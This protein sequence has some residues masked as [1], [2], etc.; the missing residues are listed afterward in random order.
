MSRLLFAALIVLVLG[1]PAIAQ[2]VPTTEIFGGYSWSH[3]KSIDKNSTG[4]SA[5][6]T[7]NFNNW[8]GLSVGGGASYA[9]VQ[10]SGIDIDL[11]S[12]SVAAGPRFSF[13]RNA[14][15]VPFA[16]I[17][18]GV[19]HSRASALGTRVSSNDFVVSGLGGVTAWVTP[20]FG[21]QFG[22][23]YACAC[24]TSGTP[25][26]FGLQLGAVFGIGAR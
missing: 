14:R 19:N 21:V 8:L 17:G 6:V 22:A 23:G 7:R 25:D 5:T 3:N 24:T 18:L 4:W 20:R 13:R 11:S 9:T 2:T 12:H 16:E 26:G 15:A 1:Q 10:E